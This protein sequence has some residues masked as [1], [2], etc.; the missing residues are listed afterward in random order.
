M[1][2]CKLSILRNIFDKL[3]EEILRIESPI[4]RFNH[5][6]KKD[7]SIAHMYP[8]VVKYMCQG[9]YSPE[10]LSIMIQ[11]HEELH[12]KVDG[13]LSGNTRRD[14]LLDNNY[15]AQAKYAEV[16]LTDGFSNKNY[17]KKIFDK[18][19]VS[20]TSEYKEVQKMYDKYNKDHMDILKKELV[21]FI[22]KNNIN[23]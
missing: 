3:Y 15:K 9:K 8:S 6:T 13:K 2:Q 5:I 16:L 18:E 12:N 22:I 11:Y 21:D 23:N 4:E 20:L 17:R 7:E 10:A 14:K 1:T 19:Y